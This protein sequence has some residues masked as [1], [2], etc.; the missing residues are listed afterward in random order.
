MHQRTR[1]PGRPFK[2]S[3][4]LHAMDIVG[5]ATSFGARG[6]LIDN[7]SQV[8]DAIADAFSDRSAAVVVHVKSSVEQT[9]AW[10]RMEAATESA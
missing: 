2:S 3:T 8:E 9:T 7:E 5:W 10:R 1:Y 4:D 6:I